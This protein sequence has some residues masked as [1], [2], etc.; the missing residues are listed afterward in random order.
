MRVD[1]GFKALCNRLPPEADLASQ[2]TITR[3]ENSISKNDLYSIAEAFVDQFVASYYTPPE[4]IVLDIDYTDD[5]T[6]RAQQLSLLNGYYDEY[7]LL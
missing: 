1:P 6:Y 4:A 2:S 7:Q 3:F 5:E